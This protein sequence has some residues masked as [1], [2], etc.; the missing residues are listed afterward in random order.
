MRRYLSSLCIRLAQWLDP[1]LDGESNQP[2]PTAI[3]VNAPV[4]IFCGPTGEMW[5]NGLCV[6]RA[7]ESEVSDLQRRIVETGG[8]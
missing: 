4:Q 3:N 8:M 1:M 7:K 2:V 5:I 6:S